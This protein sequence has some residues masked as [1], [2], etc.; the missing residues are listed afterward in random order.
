MFFN[1]PA[2]I[3]IIDDRPENLRH[4]SQLLQAQGYQV[5]RAISGE[6][7]L[8]AAIA[9]TPDLI[10]LD[11]MM[12]GM[13]G[14]EVCQKL[15]ANPKTQ[16]IPIIFLSIVDEEK[17]QI[18]A[19]KMGAVDY[20]HKP[21]HPEELLVRIEN[22]LKIHT[23]S[24]QLLAQNA[25]LE[26]E[27]RERVHAETALRASEQKY[28][29]LVEACQDMIWSCDLQGN[30][31]FVNPAVR[32]ILGYEPEEMIGC[33]CANFV[34]PEQLAQVLSVFKYV[35]GEKSV[36]QYQMVG[37]AKNGRQIYLL[38]SAIALLNSDGEVIGITGTASDITQRH[39]AEE[40]TRLLLATTQA[41]NSAKD[42]E[43]ALSAI[44]CL[45]CQ[46]I[47]WDFAEA[48]IPSQ[49]RGVLEYSL[50]GCECQ[51]NFEGFCNASK[52]VTFPPNMGLPGQIWSRQQPEWIA[53]TSQTTNPLFFRMQLA[54]KVGLRACFGV[55]ILD[56]DRVVAVL[57]FFK[58]S[59]C[60]K[61][62]HLVELVQAVAAQL[63]SLI[64]RKTAEQ[65]LQ[66]S[67]RRYQTLAEVSPVGIFHTNVQGHYT[68]VNQRCTQMTGLSLEKLLGLGWTSALHPEDSDRVFTQWYEAAAAR[69]PFK[70]EYRFVRPDGEV[71]WVIGEALPEI[72][73]EGELIGF[74]GTVTDISDRKAIEATLRQSEAHLRAIVNNASDAILILDKKGRIRFANPA[75]GELLQ[76][77]PEKLVDYEWG[78]PI[79][80]DAEIELINLSGEIIIL[81]M[82]TAPVEWL[83]ESAEV[84]TLRDIS[85][86]KQVEASLR[87]NA[88]REQAIAQILQKMRASLDIDT[89]FSTTTS[90]LRQFLQCDRAVVYRFNPDWSGE[91]VAE[92][93]T[94][95][96]IS[97][98][99]EQKDN[100]HFPNNFLQNSGCAAKVLQVSPEPLS[101]STLKATPGKTYQQ[102][103]NYLMTEDIYSARFSE[104]YLNHLKQLQA[105]AYIIVPI[106]CGEQLWGLFATY[107]NSNYR[108]WQEAEINMVVQI[109]NQ[110][111]IALQ[112]AQLLAETQKQSLAL[113]QAVH[114]ADAANRAKSEFLASMSHELRTPLNA[115]LGFTQVMSRDHSLSASHQEQLGIINRAGE[116]LLELINDI[117]ELSKIEAGRTTFNETSFDL[118]ALLNNLEDMLQNK[119]KNQ[120]LRL[121]FDLAPDLPRSIKTD[122]I[123]LRQVLINLLGNAIKF[124][125]SGSVTLRVRIGN[126]SWKMEKEEEKN[127]DPL[128]I[129]YYPLSFEI[130]DT[131]IGIAPENIDKIFE[132]FV[133]T[134]TGQQQQ[135]TGL[136]LPISR[137]FVQLMGG[138]IRVTSAP[139]QGS[140]F[141]FDIQVKLAETT[142][143]KTIQTQHKIIG[144][145]PKQPTYRIL[146]VDDIEETR[147]LLTTL[148]TSIG[149]SV[150]VAENGQVAVALWSSWSPHL[151]LM[152]MRMPVMNGY[153]ATQ[154]IK[155]HLKGQ[156][157]VIIAAT[158]SVFEE[159]RVTILSAGC[160]DFIRKPIQVDA[161]LEKIGTHLGVRYLYEQESSGIKSKK[162]KPQA[163]LTEAE[164]KDHLTKMPVEWTKK[165]YNTAC[166][167]SDDMILKLIEEIPEENYILAQTLTDLANDYQFE[168]IIKL[169]NKSIYL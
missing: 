62:P 98:L 66:A 116:H 97:L 165:L 163:S 1:H 60:A 111:G 124:T 51:S 45:I 19:L 61:D 29:H 74:V 93:V 133:Q 8:N 100:P 127:N 94:A 81:E 166:F 142:H 169:I 140:L 68:Y 145:A 137:Q 160:D 22:Q 114:A 135:G 106:F 148:L 83:G 146:V 63:G 120:G 52:Q 122:E 39:Q 119:A 75:V 76:K 48:W 12:P 131:G 67:Q 69:E 107:Q 35:L 118:I 138:D 6:L 92:S 65:A 30:L 109:G 41:I 58:C 43:T 88:K 50:N 134:E 159:Q 4:L 110:L 150:Q 70:S 40:E 123:K 14:F 89:I 28:R 117:L 104:C 20:V 36:S 113:Q 34:A 90:E 80:N 21:F 11:I 102:G 161:L 130:E 108:L 157:T 105:R 139:C 149:F 95:G 33:P 129:P 72:G 53:D 99:Q 47:G 96:W 136:G 10:L 57:V 64:A 77:P 158:A 23:L 17:A 18:T 141:A 112:Q 79:A 86:R 27:V 78:I 168:K 38:C 46:H 155:S 91:F 59:P 101:D 125:P 26:Q 24:K 103:V 31:T 164:L 151:I 49:D 128:P 55:P 7:G 44:Q 3:L 144:L 15:Q 132:A 9:S 154:Q 162:P 121:K 73:V 56:F 85:L 115:I 156:A 152:D 37:I 42:V 71:T 25:Q 147:L 82:K 143:K 2:K 153:E 54:A 84:V 87:E 16:E 32:Q 5:K 13:N 167:C 126:P